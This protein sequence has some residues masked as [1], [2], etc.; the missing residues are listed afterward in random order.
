[1]ATGIT[2]TIINMR[3]AKCIREIYWRGE[4]YRRGDSITITKEDAYILYNAGV[5]GNVKNIQE[6][7]V[8]FAVNEA[9]ENAMKPHRKRSKRG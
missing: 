7:V 8:E 4:T 2:R 9:P 3:E 6:P 5:I 1:M